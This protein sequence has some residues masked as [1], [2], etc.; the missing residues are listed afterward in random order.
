MVAAG[1]GVPAPIS[2]KKRSITW[3]HVT[4]APRVLKLVMT[5]SSN[6]I[7]HTINRGLSHLSQEKE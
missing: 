6:P 2:M 1:S 5:S 3:P 7:S 4:G